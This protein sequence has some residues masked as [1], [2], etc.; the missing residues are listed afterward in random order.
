MCRID[1]FT[2]KSK[3]PV[4]H[5]YSMEYML[6][7]SN[8]IQVDVDLNLTIVRVTSEV[9]GDQQSYSRRI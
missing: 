8:T 5:V 3:E 4:R 7:L 9:C 1:P 2:N 6:I